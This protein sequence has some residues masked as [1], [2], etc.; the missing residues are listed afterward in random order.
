MK[1]RNVFLLFC[2]IS[3]GMMLR[4]DAQNRIKSEQTD[5]FE[6]K[7]SLQ[8]PFSTVEGE[9]LSSEWSINGN[10]QFEMNFVKLH[11]GLVFNSNEMKSNNW[12]TVVHFTSNAAKGEGFAFWYVSLPGI[13]GDSFGALSKFNGL[14]VFLQTKP[15]DPKNPYLSVQSNDG[16]DATDANKNDKQLVGCSL[17]GKFDPNGGSG[18]LK[19][20]YFNG[21]LSVFYRFKEGTFQSCGK[22]VPVRL[23]EK[24]RIMLSAK[25]NVESES[26]QLHSVRVFDLDPIANESLESIKTQIA[27]IEA[28]ES[29]EHPYNPSAS[30]GNNKPP[31]NA[32]FVPNT[33]TNP[34][35][36]APP[37][38]S[39]PENIKKLAETFYGLHR[40]F[41]EFYKSV[42]DS[43]LDKMITSQLPKMQ[44]R[45]EKV[46]KISNFYHKREDSTDFQ[47]QNFLEKRN[48]N[49]VA[50]KDTA[51]AANFQKFREEVDGL[52]KDFVNLYADTDTLHKNLEEFYNAVQRNN[53]M[54][55]ERNK[56]SRLNNERTLEE[57]KRI[58]SSVGG[59]SWG[60]IFLIVEALAVVAFFIVSKVR[61]KKPKSRY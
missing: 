23:T 52:Q 42:K 56:E 36:P 10:A 12:E 60:Q 44:K 29:S 16:N 57:Y 51:F 49:H 6:T 4:V 59:I 9:K 48:I 14:G 28:L 61:S 25:S 38:V 35:S 20:R 2:A 19:I 33:V 22:S 11:S 1:I 43:V 37:L 50:L 47:N 5:P 31:V 58:H 45:V 15:E 32:G 18:K 39:N 13:P 34:T 55:Q 7:M 24:Q 21:L 3:I 46:Q 30:L 26:Y 53:D 40:Q 41:N 17:A 27:L 8:K 54:I